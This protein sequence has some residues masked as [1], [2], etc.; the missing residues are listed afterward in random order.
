MRRVLVT[1]ATGF[2]GKH[3]AALLKLGRD[4]VHLVTSRRLSRV[5]SGNLWHQCDLMSQSEVQ[6]LIRHVRPTHLLHLA[7]IATP[8]EYWTSPKNSDWVRASLRLLENFQENGGV[9]MVL[10]GTC[11]EY[12]WSFGVCSESET[13][14]LPGSMY[15]KSKVELQLAAEALAR[16]SGL[17]FAWGRIF[18]TFGPGEHPSRL[19]PTTIQALLADKFASC[20]HSSAVR[21][22]LFVED[23]AD[24]FVSLLWSDVTGVVNLASGL[25]TRLGEL[26]RSIARRLSKEHLLQLD[27]NIS[28]G[29][30]PT[31]IADTSRLH[32]LLNWR[33]RIG[34]EEGITRTIEWWEE[35]QQSTSRGLQS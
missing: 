15:G 4:E 13:P 16:S 11:A 7:W 33:P 14:I 3:C 19:V 31:V 25:P 21:D 27:D 18:F 28:P 12:D 30:V 24:A 20:H 10:A 6:A 34:I 2:I 23:L 9:R 1:G 35:F 29:F 32:R 17:Q 26:T 22:F 8:P 5:Q